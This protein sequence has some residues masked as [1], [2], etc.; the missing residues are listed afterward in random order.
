MRPHARVPACCI[1]VDSAAGSGHQA[2]ILE[3]VALRQ[4]IDAN[5]SVCACCTGIAG[6]RCWRGCGRDGVGRCSSFIQTQLCAGSVSA[7]G[8]IGRGGRMP[9]GSQDGQESDRFGS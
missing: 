4:F 2:I 3:N 5:Q 8:S 6:F 9:V 7:S 1:S